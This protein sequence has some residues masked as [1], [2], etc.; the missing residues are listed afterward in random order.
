M[1]KCLEK[2]VRKWKGFAACRNHLGWRCGREYVGEPEEVFGEA[3]K[4]KK[5][6]KAT[7]T[8]MEAYGKAI[9]FLVL[10]MNERLEVCREV[11]ITDVNVLGGVSH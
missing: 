6:V 5:T 2:G 10:R 9:V 11:G 8:S 7:R 4:A 1:K 3:D